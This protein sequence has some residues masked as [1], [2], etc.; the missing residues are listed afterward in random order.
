MSRKVLKAFESSLLLALLLSGCVTRPAVRPLESQPHIVVECSIVDLNKTIVFS[1]KDQFQCDFK[2]DGGWIQSN[3]LDL[4]SMSPEGN[5]IWTKRYY[6]HHIMRTTAA[7]DLL[8]LRS[9]ATRHGRYIRRFDVISKVDRKTGEI[10]ASYSMAANFDQL[11]KLAAPPLRIHYFADHWSPHP[12]AKTEATHANSVYELPENAL[13]AK[14]PEFAAGNVLVHDNLLGLI[15][16]LDRDL[17]RVVWSTA[18][19]RP[20][21]HALHDVQLLANGHLL[22]F[23]NH[24]EFNSSF[25]SSLD[26]FNIED[27]KIVWRYQPKMKAE[28]AS[29]YVG[30]VQMLENG[31]IFFSDMSSGGTMTEISRDGKIV[32][33][34]PH[35]QSDAA[36]LPK[37][38]QEAKRMDLTSFLKNNQ[39]FR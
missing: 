31:N 6:T 28:L 21:L 22:F 4:I 32:W 35:W 27:S 1:L 5:P 16:V 19:K 25:L 13:A 11:A 10:L 38:F 30:S 23:N 34:M 14:R 39:S 17:K 12:I 9:E 24:A 7:G 2:P 33:K 37:S 15:F 26:E 8:V 20:P 36:G 29:P 3:G 18:L